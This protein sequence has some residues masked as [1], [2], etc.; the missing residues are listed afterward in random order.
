MGNI[1]NYTIIAMFLVNIG[2][3]I[4]TVCQ[5]AFLKCKRRRIIKDKVK[6]REQLKKIEA[7]LLAETKRLE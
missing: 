6:C 1:V 7:D 4:M 3:V 5:E 2:A